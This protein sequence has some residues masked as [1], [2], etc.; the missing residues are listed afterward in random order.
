M[1]EHDTN[2]FMNIILFAGAVITVIA[3]LLFV[4]L[5]VM[6]SLDEL[7]GTYIIIMLIFSGVAGGFI[8]RAPLI[9][10]LSG[11]LGSL[12]LPRARARASIYI[13]I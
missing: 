2:P 12:A 6:F 5:F 1:H 4:M 13:N 11:L 7:S 10:A 3:L 8:T 9:G